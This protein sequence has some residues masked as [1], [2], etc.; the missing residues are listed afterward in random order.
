MLFN[1]FKS[2]STR[3]IIS[4]TK[5]NNLDYLQNIINSFLSIKLIY[6]EMGTRETLNNNEY[7]DLKFFINEDFTNSNEFISLLNF[8]KNNKT[9]YNISKDSKL[10]IYKILSEE[11]N[12]SLE[13]LFKKID[14]LSE[15]IDISNLE[16]LLN[17]FK[18]IGMI[19]C[20][21]NKWII[22]D[23]ESESDSSS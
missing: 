20:I 5:I 17:D 12:I 8:K 1:K 19:K 9:A 6:R 14:V 21:D 11:D 7:L 15:K 13:D 4:N 22:N 10:K 2:L 3:D 23:S 16:K 18:K